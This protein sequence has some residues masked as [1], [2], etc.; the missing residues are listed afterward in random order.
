MS[1][2]TSVGMLIMVFLISI[3]SSGQAP[4]PRESHTC[5]AYPR[6]ESQ[7]KRLIVY[8]GMSGC[9]L[10]DLWQ[11]NLGRNPLSPFYLLIS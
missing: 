5:V 6:S 10:G 8:G 9:R 4:P 11:L 1:Y 3:P 7:P 2:V